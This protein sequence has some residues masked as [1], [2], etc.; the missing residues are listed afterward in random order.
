MGRKLMMKTACHNLSDRLD[1]LSYAGSAIR[2]R[3]TGEAVAA[4]GRD[5]GTAAS[6]AGSITGR[7]ARRRAKGGESTS[8][9]STLPRRLSIIAAAICLG[10]LPAAIAP[11][12]ADC[13][14]PPK[15]GIVWDGC[16]LTGGSY[17]DADL[18]NA[19]MSNTNLTDA[20]LAGS[21]FSGATARHSKFNG[22]KM[23]GAV[24][25]F[26]DLTGS[27]L[28]GADLS[29]ADLN[30]A[31]LT[32]ANLQDADLSGANFQGAILDTANLTGAKLD[33][34]TLDRASLDQTIWT[35]GSVCSPNSFSSCG[36]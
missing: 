13:E 10:L 23:A 27:D 31:I 5:A 6:R 33:G 8:G 17:P 22:A 14:D 15:E 35:D 30:N 28:T 29:G 26:A 21:Q 16:D 12:Y 1:A 20:D 2:R 34:A 25:D 9:R 32:N 4:I 19:F 24:F 36:K 11:A 3:G 18:S 7:F